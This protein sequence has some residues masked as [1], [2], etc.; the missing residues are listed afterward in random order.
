M[1][2]PDVR[3]KPSLGNSA[4]ASQKDG[5]NKLAAMMP[6]IDSLDD[7]IVDA[8]PAAPE[9]KNTPVAGNN[10]ATGQPTNMPASQAT[11]AELEDDT[12][13]LTYL[14]SEV[15]GKRTLNAIRKEVDR[16]QP[17]KLLSKPDVRKFKTVAFMS[18]FVSTIDVAAKHQIGVFL[19]DAKEKIK[20]G[21]FGTYI[22]D[23]CGLSSRTARKYMRIAEVFKDPRLVNLLGFDFC[24]D[25][26]GEDLPQNILDRLQAVETRFEAEGILQE[27]EESQ[28]ISSGWLSLFPSGDPVTALGRDLALKLAKPPYVRELREHIAKHVDQAT[29]LMQR[30]DS[31]LPQFQD[32]Q[33]VVRAIQG[34]LLAP[35]PEA[36]GEAL[37]KNLFRSKSLR[38][39]L[40]S[41]TA[42]EGLPLDEQAQNLARG[43]EDQLLALQRLLEEKAAK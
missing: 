26:V 38:I 24:A 14:P 16:W 5:L 1:S 39:R 28:T 33:A 29:E 18:R 6:R 3:N 21:E 9:K 42:L 35:S 2:T 32:G 17:P 25:L 36:G 30:Y 8:V 23:A 15:I 13:L 27:W 4:S 22:E 31:L 40:D 12:S 7:D 37:A 41:L 43:I 20:H 10:Q 19:L 11:V 34:N